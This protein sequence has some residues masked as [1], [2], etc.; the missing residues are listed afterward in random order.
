MMENRLK[1]AEKLLSDEG[2]ICIHIDE[3]ETAYLKSLANEIFGKDN[4]VATFYIQ[5]R[6]PTKTLKEDMVFHKLIEHIHIYKKSNKAT[7]QRIEVEYSFEKFNWY[8]K[9]EESYKTTILGGKKVEIFKEGSYEISKRQ[10]SKDGLKEIWAS[11]TILDGTSSGRFFRDFLSERNKSDGYKVLYKVYGIG[12]DKFDYRYFTGPKRKGATRGKYYQGV[13]LEKTK[14]GTKSK[15]I[16]T[17]FYNFAANFGNCRHEGGVGLKSG[18]KPEILLR[19]IVRLFSKPSDYVVDFFAGS[20][21]TGAVAHKMRRK[22]IM[23]EI[24][25]DMIKEKALVRMKNIVKGEQ[26]GIS[27]EVGWKGGGGFKFYKLGEPL[28]IK[29]KDYSSIKIINP[30]Y[31]NTALIKVICNLEGFKFRKDDILLHGANKLGNKYAHVTEQY[32]SQGYID[33]L[34]NKL[35]DNEEMLIYCFNYDE[36]ISLPFNIIIKKLPMDLGKA[37]QLRLK[38]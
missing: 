30:K 29:H 6:Y 28:I 34:K 27:K 2:F 38:V 14:K 17:N 31:Y 13:P 21:T 33:L 32:V 23:V 1:L 20:G 10:P 19:E 26:T 9:T 37:Y 8:I 16:I 15:T 18:K 36:K 24:R 12:D 25:E 7:V 22:W 5:V 11:G 35:A 3:N 4:Y